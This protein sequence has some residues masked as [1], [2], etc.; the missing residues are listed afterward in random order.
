MKRSFFVLLLI[1]LYASH[2][3][4]QDKIPLEDVVNLALKKNY[5]VLIAENT[6]E[7]AA[8]D[9]DYSIGAFFPTINATGSRIWNTNNQKQKLP[10]NTERG[11]NGITSNNLSGSVQLNWTLFDG[12]KMFATRQRLSEIEYLGELT[13]KTQM[14]NSIADIINNYYNIVRQKQTLKAIQEQM[15]VSEERVKLASKKLEVGTG[16]KPELLQ[17]KVDL[18]AQRTQVLQQGTL[19]VQLKNQ[20]NLLTGMTLPPEFDVSDSI[21]INLNLRQDEISSN[22][23]VSNFDIQSAKSNISIA[24][25]SLHER[26]AEKFPV[27]NFISAYNFSRVQNTVVLNN[28]T[29]LFNQNKGFNYGFN[30]SVPILNGFNNRRLISQAKL[31]VDRQEIFYNQQKKQI[32]IGV[33]NAFVNYVNAKDILLIEEENI[34]LAKENVSIALE[35]FRRGIS[36]FI[37]LRTAQQ[38]LADAYNRLITARYNTKFAETELLRLNGGLLK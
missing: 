13:V 33:Q 15:A 19:I 11:G 14:V 28:F 24:Q 30:I 20:L 18:N 21:N 35:T 34:L 29:P 12:T 10:D 31:N 27:V 16:S 37:E 9:K 4:A 3:W 32:D 23:D 5:D 36:T 25:Y 26:R 17:A 7:V 22:I 6:A 2:C 1:T 8:T 38:S